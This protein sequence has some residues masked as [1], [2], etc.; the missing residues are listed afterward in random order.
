MDLLGLAGVGL[1]VQNCGDLIGNRFG[2]AVGLAGHGGVHQAAVRVA[3]HNH[4]R[5]AQVPNAVFD[6]GLLHPVDEV[7]DGAHHEEVAQAH[8]EGHHRLHARVG[9]GHDDGKGVLAVTNETLALVFRMHLVV[10]DTLQEE[11][12]ASGEAIA[13][14]LRGTAMCTMGGKILLIEVVLKADKVVIAHEVLLN[15]G[16]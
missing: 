5:C 11:V 7:A 9:A 16:N 2:H 3:E 6:A 12:I 8:G 4:K 10:V 15:S 13:C 14:L 1:A